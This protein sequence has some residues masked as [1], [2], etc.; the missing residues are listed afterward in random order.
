MAPVDQQ[1]I[2]RARP[3]LIAHDPTRAEWGGG[4]RR[5]APA[6]PPP[7]R[8][9]LKAGRADGPQGNPAPDTAHAH[10]VGSSHNAPAAII[11][12]PAP[13]NVVWAHAAPP[14]AQQHD[15]RP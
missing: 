3:G 12:E 14:L 2:R 10:M 11:S 7:Y 15:P 8:L 13:A 9:P 1:K 5:G 4:G 6:D